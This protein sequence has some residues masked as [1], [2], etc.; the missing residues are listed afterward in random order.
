M[1]D[2]DGYDGGCMGDYDARNTDRNTD[3]GERWMV[4]WMIAWIERRTDT[5]LWTGR[6]KNID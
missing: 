1:D 5:H 3:N 6:Y 4:I 2:V